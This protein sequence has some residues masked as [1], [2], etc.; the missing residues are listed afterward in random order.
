MY[1][2]KACRQLLGCPISGQNSLINIAGSL[3]SL[4]RGRSQVAS[5]NDSLAS[6]FLRLRRPCSENLVHPRL[7]VRLVLAM[8]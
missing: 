2:V 4:N 7:E 6:C 5:M 8:V 1:I 3:G